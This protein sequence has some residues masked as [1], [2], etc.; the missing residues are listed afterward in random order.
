MFNNIR[1][2]RYFLSGEYT[3]IGWVSFFVLI[4]TATQIITPFAISIVIDN[5]IVP[6]RFSEVGPVAIGLVALYTI[7]FFT[8]LLQTKTMGRISQRT[9]YKIRQKLFGTLQ[10]LP[11]SFFAKQKAGDLTSRLNSDTDKINTLLSESVVRFVGLF[12]QTVGVGIFMFFVNWQMALI[13]LCA[14]LLLVMINSILSDYALIA[15]KLAS[16]E[17]G[18]LSSQLQDDMSNYKVVYAFN[19]QQFMID[20]LTRMNIRNYKRGIQ[21]G[22]STQLYTPTFNFVSNLAL[23]IVMVGGLWLL[24]EKTIT[25]GILVGFLT[26]SRK[27]YDPLKILG[28]IWGGLQSGVASWLR[29]QEILLL[30]PSFQKQIQ[31]KS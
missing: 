11:I 6:N 29:V 1:N 26:Y 5:Y 9:L 21:A 25:I 27:F 16:K 15:N 17:V 22:F 20:N 8:A 14:S 2:L 7:N 10:Y 24:S 3:K 23:V 18:L 13:T 30:D 28:S 31:N 4:N 12:F 19:R